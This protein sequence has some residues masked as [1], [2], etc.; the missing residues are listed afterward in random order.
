MLE[1]AS[2]NVIR[3]TVEVKNQEEIQFLLLSDAHWDNPKCD[4]ET[5][6][7]DL[8]EAVAKGMRILING[9]L[10]CVMQ[11]KYD[12]R[13]SKKDIRP[14]HNVAQY[15]DEVVEDAARWFAPYAN[16]IDFVGY[17]NH[18]TAILK[19]VETD[20]IE[21][22]VTLLNTKTT[23]GHRVMK[24]GYSGFYVVQMN[25]GQ[26]S[27]SFILKYHHGF[28][29]G[30]PVTKGTIQHNRF[31]TYVEGVD[32]IWMGH[33][34]EDYELTYMKEKLDN[35]FNIVKFP[36]LMVRSAS[37]KEEFAFGEGGF[38]LEKGRPVKPVGSRILT[39]KFERNKKKGIEENRILARSTKTW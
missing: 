38:H 8:N 6:K 12:P 30:G 31:A 29:G 21:R 34:H 13:R 25:R 33:V 4:R 3:R 17:G 2:R 5:L 28:G 36:V 23:G 9:D 7:N 16:H 15:L 39:L 18:E 24:G 19:N 22:F 11:G 35:K 27:K 1:I 10:F 32:C 20:L 37:Y 14:E 26:T